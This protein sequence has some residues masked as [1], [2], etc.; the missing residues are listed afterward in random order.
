M[1]KY[2]LTLLILV[3]QF[4]LADAQ[5]IYYH[6][7]IKEKNDSIKCLQLIEASDYYKYYSVDTLLI[8]AEE[9]F[10]TSGKLKSQFFL[11][12]AFNI[13]SLALKFKGQYAA[14][15]EFSQKALKI[16][17]LRSDK[18]GKAKILL[19]YAD[20]M[21]Q[22]KKY[23]ISEQ[24]HREGLSLILSDKDSAL[25]AGYYINM[26]L[27]F[28]DMGKIDS[29][30]HYYE[31]GVFIADKV[32]SLKKIGLTAGLNLSHLA[33]KQG[34]YKELIELA[35]KVYND[36][37]SENDPDHI[38]L[39]ANN[40]ALGYLNLKNYEKALEYIKYAEDA[41]KKYN[42]PQNL[43]FA[44]GNASDIYAEK[45]DFKKAYEKALIYIG[46]KDSLRTALY[47]KNLMEMTTKYELTEKE[48]K[49]TQQKLTIEKQASRQRLIVWISSVLIL[50]VVLMFF[51][52]KSRQELKRKE[53][54]IE[55]E[56]A[57][58]S[59][60]IEHAEVERLQQM[61]NLRSKFFANISHE[62]RTPLTLILNP[63][64]QLLNNRVKENQKNYLEIIHRNASG[65]LELVNQLLELSKLESGSEKLNPGLYD[66][67][68]FCRTLC[69]MFESIAN[70]K[71][72]EFSAL[73][74]EEDIVGYFDKNILEKI[75][76]NLLSNAFKYTPSGGYIRCTVVKKTEDEI[77]ISIKDTGIGISKEN[78]GKLFNRFMSFSSSDL[79]N[80]SGIGLSIVRELVDLHKGKIEVDSEVGKGS[81]FTVLLN[82]NKKMYGGS[83]I[84]SK[85]LHN[86]G[87]LMKIPDYVE[88]SE[89]SVLN[90]NR[91]ADFVSDNKPLLLIAEDNSDVKH[92]IESICKEDF[93]IM[94][95]ENG[96]KAFQIAQ[97]KI[98]DIIITDIMMP[99]MDGMELCERL[100]AS[101]IT[102]H[103]PIIM[104]TARGDQKD[105]L[106]GL[107]K[108][109]DDYLI[110]PFDAEEIL[111]R[112]HNLL[113]QRKKLREY[114][115]RILQAF[116]PKEE[117]YESRDALFLNNLKAFVEKNIQNENYGVSELSADLSLSRSQLHRKVTGLLGF[118]PNEIIRNMRL[119]KAKMFINKKTG[120]I[121]EIAY[122]CG[123][124]SPAYFS[125]CY[126]DYFGHTPG[127]DI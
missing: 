127:E 93:R 28:A 77:E 62:L 2:R 16:N 64:E 104:L 44:V 88:D 111:L 122:N 40:V 59:A 83:E 92:L 24:Y 67:K 3:I 9:L 21:R 15:I 101:E 31:K 45:G 118:T 32:K 56:N 34:K 69:G 66:V 121:A 73:F 33:Y 72:I 115:K 14:A 90:I 43:L 46:I 78:I 39:G 75:L 126:K 41:A 74:P 10:K 22:Q 60:R 86:D 125:K 109:A 18:K 25:M 55:A 81:C 6:Q 63:A 124:S 54:Q 19:N 94:T 117:V 1:I 52:L 80:S 20:I 102:S 119:E 70:Q 100:R 36:A 61:D 17:S 71:D 65:M 79:Q 112:L 97:E 110:K 120:T 50:S 47:D 30:T 84:I 35:Q 106:E 99:E 37:L 8:L 105:K 27:M 114:Y 53:A 85:N 4:V 103:V 76:V 51:Y 68:V 107:K 11:E 38:S 42:S 108:G 49:L 96:K 87:K 116:L 123:F 98:P 48:N 5:T 29:A 12:N 23:E 58:L 82:L 91:S 26:G 113:D 13:K 57:K 7:I 89:P 95:A